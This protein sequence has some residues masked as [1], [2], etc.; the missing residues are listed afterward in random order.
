[1]ER[2]L[3][4]NWEIPAPVLALLLIRPLS[5]HWNERFKLWHLLTQDS[6]ILPTHR[7]ECIMLGRRQ[8]QKLQSGRAW[9][10]LQVWVSKRSRP[11][12]QR[13]RVLWV[14]NEAGVRAS[15]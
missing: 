13:E 8:D 7:I 1:M 2:A 12:R 15:R 9:Q 10:I 5:N 3:D 6:M 4:R 14:C 11:A